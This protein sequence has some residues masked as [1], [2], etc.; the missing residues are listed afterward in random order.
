MPATVELV[1]M[2][3]YSHNVTVAHVVQR[4]L[5]TRTLFLAALENAGRRGTVQTPA[6][7]D[8]ISTAL[9]RQP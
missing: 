4:L 5:G 2:H 9:K 3:G 8:A 7:E 1:M 6:N